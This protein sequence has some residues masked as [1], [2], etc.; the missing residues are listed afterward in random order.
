MLS[1]LRV[2]GQEYGSC[3]NNTADDCDTVNNDTVDGAFRVT[4]PA[5]KQWLQPAAPGVCTPNATTLCLGEARFRITAFYSTSQ[6]QSG[7]GMAVSLTSDSGYFWFFSAD[8]IELIVKVLDG[9]AINSEH[10]VFASG[11]TNVNVTM[12]VEDTATGAS[13]TYLNPQGQA[14][15]PLQDTS[16]FSCP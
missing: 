4:F 2:I 15:E 3:G 1:D 13:Q 5:L 14:Y 9:C 11:L 10:W 8:N 12:I 16:A 6:G 7:A